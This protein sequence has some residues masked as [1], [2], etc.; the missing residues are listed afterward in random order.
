LVETKWNDDSGPKIVQDVTFIG[1]LSDRP[2]TEDYVANVDIKGGE[3]FAY[4]YLTP[5]EHQSETI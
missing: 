2:I 1:F 4:K 3:A 5:S